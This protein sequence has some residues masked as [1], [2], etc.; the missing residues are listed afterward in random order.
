MKTVHP[1]YSSLAWK[2]I[3]AKVKA[4]WKARGW[5]CNY[6]KETL[7]WSTWCIVDHIIP[8]ADRPDLALESSNL[9]VVCHGCNS[10]KA[11]GLEPITRTRSDGFPEGWG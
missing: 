5:P 8:R 9:Q 10:R 7:D 3:R 6:C 4:Q 1:F 11:K 2:K